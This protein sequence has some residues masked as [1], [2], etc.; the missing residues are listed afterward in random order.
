MKRIVLLA[1]L[2]VIT[3]IASKGQLTINYQGNEELK[4]NVY[5]ES[6]AD[7]SELN[8]K[9]INKNAIVKYELPELNRDIA[10][11]LYPR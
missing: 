10:I 7:F 5:A 6:T 3:N 4:A 8:K 9:M 1:S 11:S 2:F